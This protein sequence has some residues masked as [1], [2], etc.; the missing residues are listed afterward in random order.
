MNYAVRSASPICGVILTLVT[1]DGFAI[2]APRAAVLLL[3]AVAECI[4]RANLRVVYI[5]HAACAVAFSLRTR[6]HLFASVCH[7]RSSG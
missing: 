1:L 6:A 7:A 3:V 4:I 5:G 2:L